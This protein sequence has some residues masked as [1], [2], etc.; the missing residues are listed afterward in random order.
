MQVPSQSSEWKGTWSASSS[1]WKTT[2]GN[3]LLI[4]IKKRGLSSSSTVDDSGA[5]WM[6]F[7]D[8]INVFDTVETCE[9][10]RTAEEAKVDKELLAFAGISCMLDPSHPVAVHTLTFSCSSTRVS[11][12]RWMSFLLSNF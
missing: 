11:R 3:E 9:V 6:S 4:A 5:F 1:A 10:K 12:P 7:N 2:E 8:F